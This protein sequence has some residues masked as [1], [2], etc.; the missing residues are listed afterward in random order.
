MRDASTSLRSLFEK[1]IGDSD[2][3]AT[4]VIRARHPTQGTGCVEVQFERASALHSIWFFRHGDGAW[5]VFPPA[6]RRLQV[7]LIPADA[8][9]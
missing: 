6:P 3:A 1:W 2:R 7:A 5:C 4:R 9:V 8:I